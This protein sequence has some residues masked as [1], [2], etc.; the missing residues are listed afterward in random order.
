MSKYQRKTNRP[1]I[2]IRSGIARKIEDWY[3]AKLELGGQK[4]IAAR[5]GITEASVQNIVIN[6]R[7][8]NGVKVP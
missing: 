7:K 3:A 1:Y 6:Y 8:R 2:K 4:Q 5:L